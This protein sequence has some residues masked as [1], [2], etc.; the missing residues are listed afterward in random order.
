MYV[1]CLKSRRGMRPGRIYDHPAGAARILI[2]RGYVE[3]VQAEA[4]PEDKPKRTKR[5]RK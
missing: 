3:A 5:R 4:E 2:Q 1:K